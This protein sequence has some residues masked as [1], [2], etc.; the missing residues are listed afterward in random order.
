MSEKNLSIAKG[1]ENQICNTS[2]DNE[3]GWELSGK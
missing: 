3:F 2:K 1:F